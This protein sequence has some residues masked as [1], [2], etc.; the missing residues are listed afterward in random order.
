[1]P[2]KRS[3][4][5]DAGPVNLSGMDFRFDLVHDRCQAISGMGQYGNTFDDWGHRFVCTNRNHLIPIVMPNHYILRNPF[6][7]VPE[8]VR[9]NQN[10]GGAA[11]V[12]PLS[13]NFTTAS[14]HSGTFT[15]SCG[16]TI[17]RGDLLTEEYRG[18]AFTC[19][20]TGNLVHQELLIGD[21][22]GFRGQPAHPGVEFLATPDDW[23]R[24]VNLAHG[25]DGAL[26]VVDMYRAVIEHPDFMPPEVKHRPDLL[27]GKTKGR[28]WR[29]VPEHFFE[30]PTRPQLS[31]ASTEQLVKL[32]AHADAWW[33]TTAQRLLLELPVGIVIVDRRYDIQAINTAAREILG[34]HVTAV[35]QDFVHL[36]LAGASSQKRQGTDDSNMASN[37]S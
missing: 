21:S 28:I 17:Y 37:N 7:A 8:P 9:D 25:P 35:G 30:R 26:Y 5:T 29:I 31:Q 22:A 10:P 1:M 12:F 36:A 20:P 24:P 4:R 14:Y 16:V 6:L 23:F 13:K 34:I 18:C 19:E 33:R 27:D 3:G 15:A 2:V 11:R 32:L